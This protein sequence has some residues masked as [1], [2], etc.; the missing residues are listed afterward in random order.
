M[1]D[2]GL[3]FVL[4]DG[5]L[6]PERK[7]LHRPVIHPDRSAT[8]FLA[9]ASPDAPA[10]AQLPS[11]LMASLARVIGVGGLPGR[12]D[13]PSYYEACEKADQASAAVSNDMRR[14]VFDWAPNR[15]CQSC[16]YWIGE[17]DKE[18]ECHLN[19][20]DLPIMRANESCPNF[21]PNAT[22]GHHHP[23]KGH[24]TP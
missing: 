15:R 8:W 12:L 7:L 10:P 23:R 19:Q 22:Q 13:F 14:Y 11:W 24:G 6:V 5:Q 9:G 3:F 21:K 20:T 2:E 1:D 4:R 17:S 16:R 18:R